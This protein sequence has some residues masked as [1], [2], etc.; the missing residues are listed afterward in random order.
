MSDEVSSEDGLVEVLGAPFDEELDNAALVVNP[1]PIEG[2]DPDGPGSSPKEYAELQPAIFEPV[3]D[4]PEDNS[5]P[6]NPEPGEV[7]SEDNFEWEQLQKEV[8]DLGAAGKVAEESYYEQPSEAQTQENSSDTIVETNR[9]VY[10]KV[11]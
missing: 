9:Y 11:Y 2:D 3:E 10:Q 5:Q 7:S 4:P 8:F 1:Q 6:A